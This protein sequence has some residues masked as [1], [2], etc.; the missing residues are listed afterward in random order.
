MLGKDLDLDSDGALG[1]GHC[2]P[3]RIDKPF[4]YLHLMVNGIL[5]LPRGQALCFCWFFSSQFLPALPQ[6]WAG[7][8]KCS[9]PSLFFITARQK[10]VPGVFSLELGISIPRIKLAGTVPLGVEAGRG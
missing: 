8:P 10:N 6:T 2:S 7:S 3:S 9:V 5:L 4:I 1:S